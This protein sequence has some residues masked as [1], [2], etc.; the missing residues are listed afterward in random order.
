MADTLGMTHSLNSLGEFHTYQGANDKALEYYTISHELREQ[1]G[2]TRFMGSSH[3]GLGWFY[4]YIGDYQKAIE[5]FEHSL[6][7]LKDNPNMNESNLYSTGF[8]FHSY[9]ILGK[10]FDKNE[11][12]E[13][14]KKADKERDPS[15]NFIIYKLVDEISYLEIA[16]D[17][18]REMEEKMDDEFKEEFLNHSDTKRIIEEYEKVMS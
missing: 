11:L 9:N 18:V 3:L 2:N 16:Y 8:L 7:L 6:D 5:H 15:L 14:I 12:K 1:M 17:Q 4:Y 13:R 10:D